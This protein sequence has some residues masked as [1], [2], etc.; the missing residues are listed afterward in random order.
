[1]IKIAV[2]LSKIEQNF[3]L[4]FRIFVFNRFIDTFY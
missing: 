4:D 3:W 2:F 1:M